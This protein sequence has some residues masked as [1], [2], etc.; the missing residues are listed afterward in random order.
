MIVFNLLGFILNILGCRFELELDQVNEG[1]ELLDKKANNHQSD[2]GIAVVLESA[3][4]GFR[5]DKV[6]EDVDFR[7]FSPFKA[8]QFKSR[9][10]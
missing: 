1:V 3:L 4:G 2:S 7:K 5:T 9:K 6:E 10:L 8:Q